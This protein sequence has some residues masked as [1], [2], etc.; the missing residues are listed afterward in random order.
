MPLD[1]IK[2]EHYINLT[3]DE[4]RRIIQVHVE[5]QLSRDVRMVSFNGAIGADIIATVY[6]K[7]E[8]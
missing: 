4:I 7:D 5:N 2:P 8:S 6:L 3:K 1:I